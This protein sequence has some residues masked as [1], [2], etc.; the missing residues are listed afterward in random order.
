MSKII[1]IEGPD[2]TGKQT[3]AKRLRD[4]LVSAGKRA[5][6]VEV[7]IKDAASY[8]A[9]YWMLR[10]G[11]A[12]KLPRTFQTIQFMNRWLFQTRTLPELESKNDIIIF[13]RWSLSTSVYGRAEGL[14]PEFVDFFYD[15]LRKPDY[16]FILIGEAHGHEPEDVYE[17]DLQ[18]QRR[19]RKLYAAWGA[20]HSH[21][22]HTINCR[23]PRDLITAEMVGV[24]KGL[25]IITNTS[26]VNFFS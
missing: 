14:S 22:S 25:G 7:P 4:Y 1:A 17:K 8:D 20:S 15:K 21:E 11:L 9:A 19:V 18:L 13:D 16:T 3:Q 24:L 6:V 2:R 26:G 5:T 23:N 10:N 12:K